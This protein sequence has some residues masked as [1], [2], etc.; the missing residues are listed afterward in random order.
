MVTE[1]SLPN[2]V[3]PAAVALASQN[4][5]SLASNP[6]S[7]RSL[8]TTVTGPDACRSARN[9]QLGPPTAT[10]ARGAPTESET[11]S[12]SWNTASL[13]IAGR[14]DFLF[15]PECQRELADRIPH[16]RLHIIERAGHN[17]HSE[18][19]AQTMAAIKDFISTTTPT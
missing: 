14:H 16:A 4:A 8:A 2:P 12:S 13:V 6:V 18:Q 10:V 5:R 7:A 15:P 9:H 3:S 11:L 17:A 19:A 1:S